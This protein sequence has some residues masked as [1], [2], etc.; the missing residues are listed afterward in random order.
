MQNKYK[1]RTYNFGNDLNEGAK[2]EARVERI[3]DDAH[4]MVSLRISYQCQEGSEEAGIIGQRQ[5]ENRGKADAKGSLA[6]CAYG[7]G[8]PRLNAMTLFAYRVSMLQVT[9][10]G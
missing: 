2:T 1:P 5:I 4:P 9:L 8:I 10:I 3:E 6:Y 7:E